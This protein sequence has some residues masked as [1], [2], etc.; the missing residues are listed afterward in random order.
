[1]RIVSSF[2][3]KKHPKNAHKFGHPGPEHRL[4]T[5]TGNVNKKL[6]QLKKHVRHVVGKSRARAEY[7]VSGRATAHNPFPTHPTSYPARGGGEN[8]RRPAPLERT[9]AKYSSDR[10]PQSTPSDTVFLSPGRRGRRP[11]PPTQPHNTAPPSGARKEAAAA[12]PLSP[13]W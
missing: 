2:V 5:T 8:R 11:R 6:N 4:F 1:M 10:P 7:R 9:T 3:L 12:A 13:S